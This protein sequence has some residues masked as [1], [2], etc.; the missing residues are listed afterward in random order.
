[1]IMKKILYL[2]TSLIISLHVVVAQSSWNEGRMEI[3]VTID[4]I[5]VAEKLNALKLNGDYYDDHARLYVTSNELEKLNFSGVN[6]EIL[7]PD[8]ATHYKNFWDTRDAY[9][10]YEEIIDLADS[11]EDN[12]PSICKKYIFG[13]S[14]QGRQLAAL[15]ISDNVDTDENEAEVMFDGGIHGDEIGGA[16]NIIRFARDLCLAYGNDDDITDLID[17]REIWLYLMVNP[18][19]RANMTRTNANGVD[20]NRDW[21][22]MWDE[23]GGSTGAYSQIEAKGLRN[24]M[25][26]HE[27]VVHT[28]YHSGTEYLGYPWSYRP[29]AAL[30]QP[31]IHNLAGIY[32]NESGYPSLGF[33]QASAGIYP[34]NGSSKDSNYGVMGSVSWT[35][36]ISYDKQPPATQIM[37]YYNYNKPS[38]T[39]MIE[40]AGYGLE[41]IITDA[42]T[43]DPVT[44]IVFVNN[45][46]QC[47]NN[48]EVGDYHKYVLP[49]SYSITVI[50]NGYAS[51]TIEDVTVEPLSSTIINFELEPEPGDYAYKS[52]SSR[53]PGNNEADEGNTPAAFGAPDDINYSIGKNGW[54][55]L[56]M[57]N[58]V[59]DGPTMDL[60]VFE[61][62]DDPEGFFCYA[63]TSIDGPWYL[64]GEGEGT[65]EFDL[66]ETGLPEAQFIKIVD[67]GN[68][69]GTVAN[70]GFD[71]D[72][73]QAL[74]PVSG[75][76]ITL[77]DYS[78]EEVS[79]NNNGRIDPGE[80]I[81][82]HITL[83]NNG[84]VVAGDLTGEISSEQPFITIDHG[85]EIF[86]DV[87][88]F[89]TSTG[90]YTFSVSDLTPV[91]YTFG[92]TLDV[93][94]NNNSYTNSFDLNFP[95]GQVIEDFETGDFDS[96]NWYE[97]G[98]TPWFITES[99]AFEGTFAAQSGAINDNQTSML[100]V[101]MEVIAA[102]NVSFARRVSS[103]SGYDFL[104]FWIDNQKIASWSGT[105][106]WEEVSYSVS[107]GL[108]T[109]KWIYTK[110]SNTSNGSDCGWVDMIIFPPIEPEGMGAVKGFVTD[111]T[112]GL[113]IEGALVGGVIATDAT[114]YYKLDLMPGE[115]E[116]CTSHEEYETLCLDAVVTESDTTILDF[117]LMPATGIEDISTKFSIHAYPNPFDDLTYLRLNLSEGSDI[118]IDILDLSGRN[119]IRLCDRYLDSGNYYFEWNGNNEVGEKMAG[120]IYFYIFKSE[121]KIE[122]G[123]LILK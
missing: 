91:G 87:A 67:D 117:E 104:E 75:V 97:G 45:Y 10:T 72:A 120:G 99:G 79:G 88:Q 56:D 71:L 48:P 7:I 31:H 85:M 5:A 32:V 19:G 70:A 114:G 16:E 101:T 24:C 84:D 98:D 41:G 49:G 9:H 40:H 2:L 61:G 68:G 36:E 44:A 123:K 90:T 42:S 28:T 115:Y 105:L 1:M 51:Q 39:A 82:L 57:Q 35:M 73:I 92:I 112:T 83:R 3:E 93:L 12:F 116:I 23:W 78:I 74:E 108:H 26:N 11:L 110:D 113:P 20:L 37:L 47:Y 8:L 107:A 121:D 118:T 100:Y 34:I 119:V 38:M 96:F 122:S 95:V 63:S 60:L 103:E 6:Y 33:G 106:G 4:N 22:Y 69:M 64:V 58:P 81:D 94:A 29:Q 55:V 14:M 76:Y 50:A 27:F 86:G 18:D 54:I 59:M 30:D 46:F 43:G 15:K 52:P 65:T 80:T 66:V 13:V 89:E 77:F 109:F 111:F 17:N 25:Y 102:G 21:G 53:I 62:D